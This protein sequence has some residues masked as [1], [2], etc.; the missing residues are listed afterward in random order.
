M[1]HA[2]LLLVLLAVVLT[3]CGPAM[4]EPC[5]ADRV[6]A[7]HAQLTDILRRWLN[8]Y[9]FARSSS[10][11]ALATPIQAMQD[12]KRDVEKVDVPKCLDKAKGYLIDHMSHT[13]D[14]FRA[15]MTQEADHLVKNHYKLACDAIAKYNDEI[16][17]VTAC[18]P[19]CD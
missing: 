12:I 18:A 15:F 2:M 13:V 8:V 3:A 7:T 11:N 14:L 4:P 10:W 6:K 9:K 1:K 17:L 19:N 5:D 16:K